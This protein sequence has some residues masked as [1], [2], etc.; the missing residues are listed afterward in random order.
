MINDAGAEVRVRTR[1]LKGGLA[2]VIGAMTLNAWAAEPRF[3][4]GTAPGQFT[5]NPH[6]LNVTNDTHSTI[7]RTKP[8]R[9]P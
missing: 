2:A 6:P 9:T 1:K 5:E 7:T 8:I 4:V 3:E